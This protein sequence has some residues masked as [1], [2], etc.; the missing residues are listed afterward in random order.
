M[1]N[2]LLPSLPPCQHSSV[3][4]RHL[5]QQV[6]FHVTRKSW[7]KHLLCVISC[8]YWTRFCLTRISKVWVL[9]NAL[10]RTKYMC[11]V[12]YLQQTN[13]VLLV[14]YLAAITK[15][16]ATASEV[17]VIKGMLWWALIGF[18]AAVCLEDQ[19]SV[20]QTRSR[21]E[22]KGWSFVLALQDYNRR[23]LLS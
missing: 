22:S 12:L 21:Q 19:C 10:H 2:P 7:E 8:Q 23:P 4:I 5:M 3:T 6:S 15:G 20:W 11:P 9:E 14:S 13:E 18:P 17:G 1:S 16:T